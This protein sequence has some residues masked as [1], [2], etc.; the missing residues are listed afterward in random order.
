MSPRLASM[1]D[2]LVEV[3]N[4]EENR[5]QG[6]AVTACTRISDSRSMEVP[7]AVEA[8]DAVRHRFTSDVAPQAGDQR[9]VT[10][11]FGERLQVAGFLPP[12]GLDR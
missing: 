2:E 10:A 12:G 3:V 9:A 8:G 11:L 6:L 7:A 5:G 1:L 4:F